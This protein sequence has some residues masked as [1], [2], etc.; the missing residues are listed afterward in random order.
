MDFEVRFVGYQFVQRKMHDITIYISIYLSTYLSIYRSIYLSIYL[1]LSNLSIYLSVCLSV[2]LS[3]Y[4]SICLSVYLSIYL[5]LSLSPSLSVMYN[6]NRWYS[7]MQNQITW[8]QPVNKWVNRPRLRLVLVIWPT[9]SRWTKSSRKVTVWYFFDP[10]TDTTSKVK[11]RNLSPK[12]T[13]EVNLIIFWLTCCLP[14]LSHRYNIRVFHRSSLCVFRDVQPT[15]SSP[16]GVLGGG[17]S[18]RK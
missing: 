14:I 17:T 10:W 3:I 7:W 11:S 4:L 16:R 1:Y 15:P 6:R 12:D 18:P 2:Y 8:I 5:S 13:R 9:F